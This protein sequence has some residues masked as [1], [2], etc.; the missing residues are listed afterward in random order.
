MAA[1][2][3]GDKL[4]LLHGSTHPSPNSVAAR[5]NLSRY[6]TSCR[7]PGDG[8]TKHS[9]ALNDP[10]FESLGGDPGIAASLNRQRDVGRRVLLLSQPWT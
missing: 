9:E 6:G 7:L 2:F 8:D 4:V 10:A 5:S 1:D 3:G